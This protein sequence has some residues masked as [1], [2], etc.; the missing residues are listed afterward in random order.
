VLGLREW[1]SKKSKK[2]GK[3]SNQELLETFD[4]PIIEVEP[5]I[6]VSSGALGVTAR[7]SK[8]KKGGT[9][10]ESVNPVAEALPPPSESEAIIED[11]WFYWGS[12]NKKSKK[13]KGKCLEVHIDP[14]PEP[15][16]KLVLVDA[17]ETPTKK[18]E[19]M[20]SVLKPEPDEWAQ[21]SASNR[22]EK[23]EWGEPEVPLGE[24][25]SAAR[26]SSAEVLDVPACNRT[27][28]ASRRSNITCPGNFHRDT[29]SQHSTVDPKKRPNSHIHDPI[30]RRGQH[31]T[32]ASND[33]PCRQYPRSNS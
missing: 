17:L 11:A 9:T 25:L 13:T 8:K 28:A 24:E 22:S 26:K 3:Q 10:F 7:K 4:E 30:A 27:C 2:T 6:E 12:T 1:Q 14:A 23:D 31:E 15:K 21:F 5:A 18:G 16:L 20:R 32:S 33:H 29:Y 19:K